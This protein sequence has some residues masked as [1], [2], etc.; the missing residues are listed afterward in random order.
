MA[1]G[2]YI[3]GQASLMMTRTM[4]MAES[5]RDQQHAALVPVRAIQL[6]ERRAR[7]LTIA[8]M[9]MPRGRKD[10]PAAQRSQI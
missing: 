2:G 8:S 3:L 4:L 1:A 6:R 9:Q 10:E 7:R 5:R